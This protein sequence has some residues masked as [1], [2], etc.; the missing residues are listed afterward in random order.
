MKN[1]KFLVSLF[2]SV[3][4][5]NMQAQEKKEANATEFPVITFDKTDHDFGTIHEKD[6]VETTFKFKNTGN[7]P[8]LITKIKASCG[9]T[10]PSNWT[11]DPILPGEESQFTVKFNS[12][13]KP[14]KQHKRITLT[15]NTAA[16]REY[17]NIRANVIPD[18]ELEKARQERYKKIREQQALR[19]AEQAKKLEAKKKELALSKEKAAGEAKEIE[20]KKT[21][22]IAKQKGQEKAEKKEVKLNEK[23]KEA[24]NKDAKTIEKTAVK[25]KK[26]NAKMAK[27]NK[28]IAKNKAANKKLEARLEKL[29]KKL[30]KLK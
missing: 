27:L 26:I 12:R 18:P 30:K 6:I 22:E 13:N 23:T 10:I 17:V 14:N 8:L 15:C 21:L 3:L 16:G 2:I 24:A 25:A 4:A 11:K 1:L 9:C 28:Q 7:A 29:E 20:K 5:F 19:K